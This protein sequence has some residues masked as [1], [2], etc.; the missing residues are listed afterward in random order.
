VVKK[1]AL[2]AC[3]TLHRPLTNALAAAVTSA[4]VKPR[5]S[6]VRSTRVNDVSKAPSVTTSKPRRSSFEYLVFAEPA[7]ADVR[8]A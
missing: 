5:A 8:R 4:A 7:V 3:G 6:S 2:A 1:S